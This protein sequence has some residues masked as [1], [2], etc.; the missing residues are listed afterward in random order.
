M[1]SW[2]IVAL[3]H[4]FDVLVAVLALLVGPSPFWPT[5]WLMV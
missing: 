3:V 2:R 5:Y 4:G 1:E